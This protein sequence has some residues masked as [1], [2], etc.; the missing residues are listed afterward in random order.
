VSAKVIATTKR[1]QLLAK[2]KTGELTR[3]TQA[4]EI[5]SQNHWM[6]EL[7]TEPSFTPEEASK[8]KYSGTKMV[9]DIR[10][11]LKEHRLTALRHLMTIFGRFDAN[12][13]GT[14]S[15]AELKKGLE[16]FHIFLN[17]D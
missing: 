4:K 16:M 2:E 3:D 7:A 6:F 5:G 17:D 8:I 10:G 11:A 15:P 13:D 12:K 9:E 1:T 14:L